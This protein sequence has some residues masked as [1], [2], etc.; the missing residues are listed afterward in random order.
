M[1]NGS[2]EENQRFNSVAIRLVVVMHSSETGD[3]FGLE[4]KGVRHERR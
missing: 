2:F 1:Q 4:R 3:S